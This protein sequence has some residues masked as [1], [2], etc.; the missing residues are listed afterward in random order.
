MKKLK[1]FLSCLILIQLSQS[2]IYS[3]DVVYSSFDYTNG[4]INPALIGDNHGFQ[5]TAGSR[6]QWK[7]F[8]GSY[9]TINASGEFAFSKKKN[10]SY[11]ASGVDFYTDNSGS[12]SLVTNSLKGNLVYHLAISPYDKLSLGM[13]LGY[14]GFSSNL[15]NE[16]WGSQFD[17]VNYNSSISSGESF[18]GTQKNTLDAGFGVTYS[19]RFESDLE[20]PTFQIGVAAYHLNRPNT[21]I[22]N[23]NDNKLPIRWSGFIKTSYLI[24]DTKF[25]IKPSINAQFQNNFLYVI[26]G[27]MLSLNYASK[28]F[29]PY[30]K[31]I[32]ESFSFGLF[33]R[34]SGAVVGRMSYQK[35][36]WNVG[37]SYDINFGSKSGVG[38]MRSA[39]EINLR[40]SLR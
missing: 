31:K 9:N 12:G 26:A 15:D 1:Y 39:A 29:F 17:G 34:S 25:E 35:S 33:Y 37:V 38:K 10:K 4:M 5:I 14:L 28:A 30:S 32:T 27:S 7:K 19:T 3:Q 13:Y 8:G 36:A 23:S 11:L 16:R 18:T 40:Y 20:N 24:E 6:S 22:I 2:F 21:S